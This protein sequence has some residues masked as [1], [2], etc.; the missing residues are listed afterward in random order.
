MATIEVE[1]S[2]QHLWGAVFGS[3]LE[4]AGPW[5][6]KL[7]YHGDADSDTIGLVEVW[8]D[9]PDDEEQVLKVKVGIDDLV[10]GLQIV[11][12][13]GTTHCGGIFVGDIEDPDSCTPDIIL[14]FAVFGEVIYG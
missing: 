10:K 5:W 14:Q 1:V 9:N 11:Y 8:V 13:E 12:R 7:K 4:G 2:E 6:R 3:D